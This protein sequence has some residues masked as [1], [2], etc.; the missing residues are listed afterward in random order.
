MSGSACIVQAVGGC[1]APGPPPVTCIT[2]AGS[3]HTI[4]RELTVTDAL[5]SYTATWNGT[6]YWVTPPLCS[7]NVTPTANCTSGTASCAL[8]RQSAPAIYYYLIGCVSAGHMAVFR[9][10]YF[11]GCA[12]GPSYQYCPCHC[13]PGVASAAESYASPIAVTC[14]SISWSGTL[15]PPTGAPLT[16]PVGGTVS[17]NQ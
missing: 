4:P 17:F 15:T 13:N 10:Y 11:L 5:G 1:E 12:M 8:S 3:G 7:G 14:G 6:S 16:D 2:C 9:Q